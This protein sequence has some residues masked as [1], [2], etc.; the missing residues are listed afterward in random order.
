MSLISTG[1]FPQALQLGVNKWFGRYALLV[2]E[3][4]ELFETYMSEKN[5]E[6]DV[7]TWGMGLAAAIPEGMDPMY[8]TAGQ[9]GTQR[10]VHTDYGLG[11]V[12]TRNAIDDNLYMDLAQKHTENLSQSMVQTKDTIAFNLLNNGFTSSYLCHDGV[13]IYSNA[14]L[15]YKGGTYS[16]VLGT[17]AD[18]SEDALEQLIIQ[19]GKLEND[20]GLKM[21]AFAKKLFIPIDLQFVAKRILGSVLRPGVSSGNNVNDVNALREM[22]MI[23]DGVFASHYL[24]DPDA[25][26]I[27]TNVE[28]GY[29]VFQRRAIAIR[30]DTE[31][32]SQNV[33]FVIDERYSVGITDPRATFGCPG[34]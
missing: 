32:N 12:I 4:T 5:Y 23:P 25:Y 21:N 17:P 22:G 6:F 27:Q 28:D 30:N 29:K 15:N 7:G 26:F 9:G 19:I 24:S 10:Y 31:F 1:S 18:L 11:F 34:A 14:H 33:R 13:G 16:N 8:D 20:A 3:H 2:K